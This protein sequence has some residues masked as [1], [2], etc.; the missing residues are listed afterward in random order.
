MEF[1]ALNGTFNIH[2]LAI[3]APASRNLIQINLAKMFQFIIMIIKC[4][5]V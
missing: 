1:I 4:G 3:K 5:L 2:A